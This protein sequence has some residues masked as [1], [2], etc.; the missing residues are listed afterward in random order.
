MNFFDRTSQ[1]PRCNINWKLFPPANVQQYDE[2]TGK[3]IDGELKRCIECKS[4]FDSN[5]YTIGD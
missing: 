4:V 2:A 5:G 3:Y 1:C